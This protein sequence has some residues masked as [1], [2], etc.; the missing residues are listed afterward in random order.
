[1]GNISALTTA[2]TTATTLNNLILVSPQ[3]T[4]GYQPINPPV[5]NGSP[6]QQPQ[7]FL[8]DYE[9]E[10]IASIQ[11][12]ITDHYIEDNTALQDQIALRP[13]EI[14]VHG[15]IGELNDVVPASLQALQTVANKLTT[16]AAYTPSL[17]VSALNAYNTAFQLYQIGQNLVTNSISS[18]ASIN[19]QGGQSDESVISNQIIG[20]APNQNRQQ[21]MFQ[22]LY[23]YW[24]ARVL[25]NIQ[26]PWA[27]FQNMAIKSLRAIQDAST[28]VITDFEITF[29]TIRIAQTQ[30]T[31]F[32]TANLQGRAAVQG[33][34]VTNLGTSTPTNSTVLPSSTSSLQTGVTGGTN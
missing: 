7:S 24:A 5:S 18:W 20:F 16:I 34:G 25:F 30:I 22:Q 11:S 10:N 19:G 27:I 6:V 17:S 1:M 14:T 31:T 23:G 32:N 28:N 21:V 15:F 29:K 13:E 2:T 8:F 12:D 26:T 4:I 3:T 9:G 33:A